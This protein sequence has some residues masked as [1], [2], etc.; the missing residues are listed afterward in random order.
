MK[1]SI[2]VYSAKMAANTGT[3]IYLDENGK[4]VEVVG[5]YTSLEEATQ[6]RWDDVVIVSECLVKYLREEKRPAIYNVRKTPRM[7][8]FQNK[9]EQNTKYEY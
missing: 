2:G 1:Y 5:V 6:C 3:I 8:V 7:P 4:E 9:V